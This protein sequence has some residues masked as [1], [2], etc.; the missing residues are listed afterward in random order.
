MK[1]RT[2]VGITAIPLFILLIF[3]AP[4]WAFSIAVG[5]ISAGAAWEFLRCVDPKMPI[6]FRVYASVIAL[7]IPIVYVVVRKSAVISMAVYFLS[8]LMFCELLLSFRK[9]EHVK[10]E[11]LL[12]VFFA[13]NVMP[14]LL[15]SLVRIG[16]R[17]NSSV[18]LFLPLVA[19]FS[20][21]SGAYFAGSFYGKR[22]IF[23][24][25]SPN[26]SLEGCIGGALSAIIMMI[27]YGIV[28]ISFFDF[29]VNFIILALYGLFGSAACQFGDLAFSAIKREFG[30]KD[31][32]KLIPG[33]GGMLDRFDSMHFT[34][35]MIEFLVLLL[36][37]IV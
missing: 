2:I 31:Y 9:E 11:T 24:H 7:A 35:P 19:A 18:Y 23:P 20:S 17:D 33:H 21:D 22:K 12:Q 29:K 30:I 8:I 6:R 14:I 28:L 27:I 13:G 3:F 37:A 1:T 4:L 25:L 16:I 15:A 34:A 32:G 10:F 26:K 36:P 5:L